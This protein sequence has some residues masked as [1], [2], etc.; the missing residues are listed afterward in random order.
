MRLIDFAGALSSERREEVRARNQDAPVCPAAPRGDEDTSQGALGNPAAR[1]TRSE[2]GVGLRTRGGAISEGSEK[3]PATSVCAS[4]DPPWK[5]CEA[6]RA[7]CGRGAVAARGRAA[8]SEA[9]EVSTSTAAPLCGRDALVQTCARQAGFGGGQPQGRAADPLTN[10]GY[11][12]A[13]HSAHAEPRAA[14]LFLQSLLSEGLMGARGRPLRIAPVTGQSA[15][16]AAQGMHHG[17]GGVGRG[18]WLSRPRAHT[19]SL[20]LSE[21]GGV[22]VALFSIAIQ[23]SLVNGLPRSLAKDCGTTRVSRAAAADDSAL[24]LLGPEKS[25]LCGQA[26]ER[27]F[28]LVATRLG[29]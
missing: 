24:P 13:K 5:G 17:F 21:G 11:L 15:I 8:A 14:M 10:H 4:H 2:A 26:L 27:L 25:P 28:P 18:H 20:Y 29:G 6:P 7:V 23:Q 19:R 9:G 3:L 1:R 22:E 16:V 12:T